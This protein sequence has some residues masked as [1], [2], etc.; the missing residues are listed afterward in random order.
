LKEEPLEPDSSVLSAISGFAFFGVPHRGLAV[1]CL[2]PLVKDNPNRALL[3]SLNRNSSLLDRLQIEFDKISTARSFSVV[4]FYET[5]KSPT[6]ALVRSL[7]Q[8]KPNSFSDILLGK[9]QVGDVGFQRSAGRSGLR[10]MRVSKA[11]SHQS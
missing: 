10:D 2:V 9:W 5:E 7:A 3:E 11:A 1:Q 8:Y 6:G 4:S